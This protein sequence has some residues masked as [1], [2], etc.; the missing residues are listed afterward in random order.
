MSAPPGSPSREVAAA[1]VLAEHG[2][3]GA[4]VRAG[5]PEGEIALLTA[6]EGEWERLLDPEAGARIAER[7]RAL[8]FRYV[9]LELSDDAE[10]E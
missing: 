6:P 1:R 7:I 5:G 9:A 4:G 2:L 3:G 8:G 10:R